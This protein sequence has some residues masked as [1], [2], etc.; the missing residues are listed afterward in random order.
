MEKGKKAIIIMVIGLLLTIFT[1][2]NF[3]STGQVV[4][5]GHVQITRNTID[6]NHWYPLIGI[7]V[8]GI[9]GVMLWQASRK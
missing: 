5:I 1:L 2:F 8:M 6:Q 7:V 9:G 3:S 4:D